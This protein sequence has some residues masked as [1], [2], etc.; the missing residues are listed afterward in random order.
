MQLLALALVA[1]RAPR[2]CALEVS[3]P[4]GGGGAAEG[5]TRL[6]RRLWALASASGLVSCLS[7]LCCLFSR[8]FFLAFLIG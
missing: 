1:P 7:C 6:A 4:G 8:A 5:Y 2:D 3:A